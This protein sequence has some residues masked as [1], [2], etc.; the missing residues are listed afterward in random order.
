MAW[1]FYLH[2]LGIIDTEDPNYGAIEVSEPWGWDAVE[3]TLRKSQELD[4]FEF[5]FSDT[6]MFGEG[7]GGLA[8]GARI[9]RTAY[10]RDGIDAQVQ[11][12]ITEAG[13]DQYFTRLINFKIYSEEDFCGDDCSS[14]LVKV[15]VMPSGFAETFKNRMDVAINLDSANTLDGIA[16]TASPPVTIKLHSKEILFESKLKLNEALKELT[17]NA[18]DNP[19]GFTE[20]AVPFQLI[21]SELEQSFEPFFYV[22]PFEQPL[23][24][25]GFTLPAGVNFRKIRVQGRAKFTVT[26]THNVSFPYG[27]NIVAKTVQAGT[28]IIRLPQGTQVPI[29]SPGTYAYD[30]SFDVT[31]SVPADTNIFV[32][33]LWF[34]TDHIVYD[35]E[36]SFI[37][38]SENSIITPSSTK[39]YFIFEAF[40]KIVESVTGIPAA[41]KS[42]FFESGCGDLI[43]I[44]NGKNIRQLRDKNGNLFPVNCS[45]KQLFDAC[46]AV[47]CLGM[48]VEK[49]DTG[50]EFVRVEPKGYFYQ[51]T[52]IQDHSFVP[53]II[54]SVSL[55]HMYNEFECGYSKWETGQT[56]GLDEFNSKRNYLIP[57]KNQKKK[58]TQFS[59]IIAGGYLIEQ[60]R[61][62]QFKEKPTEDFATDDDLFYICTNRA[63]VTA[64]VYELN[65]DGSPKEATYPIGTVS[66]RAEAFTNL[67]NLLSPNTA[68]NLRLSPAR[69]A[70]H[71]W[72]YL[73]VSL[74]RKEGAIISFTSGAG[75]YQMGSQQ[76]DACNPTSGLIIENENLI[77]TSQRQDILNPL[78]APETL[79]FEAPM[80]LD[81]FMDL[82]GQSI[83][84]IGVSCDDDNFMPA[85][86]EE[87]TYKPNK[88]GGIAS[89]RTSRGE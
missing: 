50:K 56:N 80:N 60:T 76:N 32:T 45:F 66:E 59:N 78:F 71:W 3:F 18:E 22:P 79:E 77:G 16:I 67:T 74:F 53:E 6:L 9:L 72:P 33:G 43:T 88:E 21:Q 26:R 44:T 1:R 2:D 4:G 15:G 7:D 84:Q 54:R 57:L 5:V 83:Y 25:S 49:D 29:N 64:N 58:L 40:T 35:A 85:Y 46:K 55:E 68:Y 13:C 75:N 47:W 69:M 62:Q 89:F 8:S 12:S 14:G 17:S 27:I 34:G 11:V 48:R 28:E 24:Y 52:S 37:N 31:L 41:F 86:L 61:R 36:V 19:G 42:T 81:G 70:H 87:V 39:A 38:L 10:V 73:A 63:E 82:V 23:F 20:H 30:I 51:A 65:A